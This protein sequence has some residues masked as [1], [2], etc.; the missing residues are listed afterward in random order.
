M[1]HHQFEKELTHLELIFPLIVRDGAF[2]LS[3]WRSRTTELLA[4]QCVI[5]SGAR[6]IV[7]LLDLLDR[8][9]QQA[10]VASSP[11]RRNYSR[12]KAGVGSQGH[13]P[14]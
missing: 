5:P 10:C 4:Y 14:P 1:L 9:E 13:H 7:W 8:I 3:Y 2:S 12:T 6:R 11:S